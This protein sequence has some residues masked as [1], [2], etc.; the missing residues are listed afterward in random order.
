MIAFQ[1][2]LN[3]TTY[4]RG[5]P[6]VDAP[7]ARVDEEWLGVV[8]GEGDHAEAEHVGGRGA[9]RLEGVLGRQEVHVGVPLGRRPVVVLGEGP[10]RGLRW[11]STFPLHFFENLAKQQTGWQKS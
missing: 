3:A 2:F 6:L 5:V 4:L 10:R 8:E 1:H 7:V 9:L 11:E